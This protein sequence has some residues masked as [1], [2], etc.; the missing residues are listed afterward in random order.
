MA[1]SVVQPIRKKKQA[2]DPVPKPPAFTCKP[3]KF[4]PY[5]TSLYPKYKDRITVYIYRMWPVI[6]RERNGK[7]KYIDKLGEPLTRD[8]MAHRY[9]DGDYAMHLTD[10]NREVCRTAMHGR[11]GIRNYAPPIIDVQDLVMD[12][13][14]NGTY[15]ETLRSQG[16]LERAKGEDEVATVQAVSEITSGMVQM[17]G[18]VLDKN[19][20]TAS[21]DQAAATRSIELISSTANKVV[22]MVKDQAAAAG[23][24]PNQSIEILDRAAS[25]IERMT[26]KDASNGGLKEVMPLIQVA[27]EQ[28]K[29]SN[30]AQLNFLSRRLEFTES[31]LLKQQEGGSKERNLL[32]ELQQL[33][34]LRE[35]LQG[36]FG[37]AEKEEREDPGLMKYLPYVTAGLG[38]LG[39]LI[40]NFAVAKTGT[41]TP[42]KPEIPQIQQPAPK[43]EA[44]AQTQVQEED[45]YR[46]FLREIETPLLTSLRG[47]E[48]G[49]KF[50]EVLIAMKGEF[51]FKEIQ[52]AGPDQL[53][54]LLK[55]DSTLFQQL[56]ADPR[57]P[58]FLSEFLAGPTQGAKTQ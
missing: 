41:G 57:F 53:L 24:G 52:R 29:A 30:E 54:A 55:M 47:G 8:D 14:A 35:T 25:I 12:D 46:A 3:E 6:N 50:A 20:S 23:G 18:K 28:S 43:E 21:A 45:M 51:I 10:G 15:I 22:D 49:G 17:M 32:S 36:V 58:Q 39:T 37:T 42:I 40:Y 1:T 44:Q 19:A 33:A 11:D 26:A 9:G 2:E 48:S 5:W 56:S 38:V 13:P 27:L 34:E 31:L 7:K 16:I 4:F